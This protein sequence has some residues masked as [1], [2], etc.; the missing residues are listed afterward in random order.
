MIEIS[1]E[2]LMT[3]I[4]GALI[5]GLSGYIIDLDGEELS[6]SDKWQDDF[7]V[8]L[9]RYAHLFDMSSDVLFEHA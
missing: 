7:K 4:G 3:L 2:D 8:V 6:L 1:E 5:G 9:D